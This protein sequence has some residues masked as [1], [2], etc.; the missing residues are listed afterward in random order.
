[1]SRQPVRIGFIES[2][3]LFISRTLYIRGSPE[4][5]LAVGTAQV[6]LGQVFLSSPI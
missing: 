5:P 1:M 4:N 3:A 2:H 6:L